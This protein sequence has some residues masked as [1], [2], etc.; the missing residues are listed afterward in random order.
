[1]SNIAYSN[2]INHPSC[3]AE[4]CKR[5]DRDNQIKNRQTIGTDWLNKYFKARLICTN[6]FVIS[7]IDF[8]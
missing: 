2:G 5:T 4:C 6:G 8:F 1:M 7:V 3:C